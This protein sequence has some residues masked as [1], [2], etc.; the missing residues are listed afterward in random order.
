[1]QPLNTIYAEEVEIWP[2]NHP[3]SV[4]TRYQITGMVGKA[5]LK[6]ATVAIAANG[7]QKT[8]FF[9]SN[10]TY[11]MILEESQRNI[12]SCSFGNPVR[13]TRMTKETT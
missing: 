1:M 2:K 11:L 10:A 13:C 12:M 4:V 8:G 5:Y 7:F 9:P 6:S 3:N